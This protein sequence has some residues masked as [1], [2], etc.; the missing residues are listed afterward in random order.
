M[1]NTRK[2]PD[3]SQLFDLATVRAL[4]ADSS[5]L[6]YLDRLE[7]LPTLG[8]ELELL[9][10]PLVVAEVGPAIAAAGLRPIAAAP[11]SPG[12]GADRQVLEAA[13]ARR[14]GLLSDDR[15]LLR[16]AEDRGLAVY[17]A[18]DLVLLCLVRGLVDAAGYRRGRDA[19]ADFARYDRRLLDRA[20]RLAFAAGKYG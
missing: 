10:V 11:P 4:V 13:A 17:V 5:S 2:D 9:A 20:D 3:E 1:K 15:R 12:G 6:I 14:A 8:A 16:A 19:L 18:L 7:L